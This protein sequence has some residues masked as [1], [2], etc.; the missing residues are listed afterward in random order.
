MSHIASDANIQIGSTSASSSRLV[1]KRPGVSKDA[2]LSWLIEIIA[3]LVIVPL[4][5]W[6]IMNIQNFRPTNGPIGIDRVL[7]GLHLR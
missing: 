4:T 6:G 7:F 2:Y 3:F 5:Q 1:R